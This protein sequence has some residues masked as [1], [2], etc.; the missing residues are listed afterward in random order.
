M[1]ND[2][3]IVNKQLGLSDG[4]MCGT[5]YK[6][7]N[8]HMLYWNTSIFETPISNLQRYKYTT[9]LKVGDCV[10]VNNN[11]VEKITCGVWSKVVDN[12]TLLNGE[13][14]I[15]GK[16][17]ASNVI[18]YKTL[19]DY[20]VYSTIEGIHI[21]N[22]TVEQ[23]IPGEYEDF[24]L[25]YDESIEVL[26]LLLISN[27]VSIQLLSNTLQLGYKSTIYGVQSN[28]KASIS[29]I[30]GQVIA[31]ACNNY[32]FFILLPSI[33]TGAFSVSDL[34]IDNNCINCIDLHYDISNGIIITVDETV[35]H[36]CC[37]LFDIVGMQLKPIYCKKLNISTATHLTCDVNDNYLLY[38]D[39]GVIIFRLVDNSISLYMIC[40]GNGVFTICNA[41]PSD[42]IGIVQAC[43]SDMCYVCLK[44]SICYIEMPNE[45]IGRKIYFSN[46]C[47]YG[48]NFI[49]QSLLIG[50]C[51]GKDKLLVGL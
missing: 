35:T 15:N 18:K 38:Y 8:D 32:K 16:L 48:V 21:T 39:G 36:N 25:E 42:F 14:V 22:N 51:I 13:L 29:L 31:I 20:I 7:P 37:Q 41:Q 12:N 19:H 11:I 24:N 30:P 3:V 6:K 33:Y 45:F 50:T 2:T 27:V 9:P 40:L 26:I 10:A 17:I 1:T 43:E 4:S 49:N 5:L 23:F 46:N 34:Y 28:K 44:G 47:S